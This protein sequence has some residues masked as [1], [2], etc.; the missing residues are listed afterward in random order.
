MKT[1]ILGT[2]LVSFPL[3]RITVTSALIIAPL[4]ALAGCTPTA[5]G[6]DSS[7]PAALHTE[8]D[9]PGTTAMSAAAV[10]LSESSYTEKE[11]YAVGKAHRYRGAVTGSLE[12]AEQIDEDATPYSTRVLVRTP[13][14]DKFNG[15]LIVEWNNVTRNIDANFTFS[16]THDQIMREGYA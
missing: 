2:P 7:A 15:T 11:Y 4:L 13:E 6:A 16:E 5:P 8:V 12:T 9:V 3:M 14:A 10:D 1:T